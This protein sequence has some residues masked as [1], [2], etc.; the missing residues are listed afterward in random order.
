L[1]QPDE[2]GNMRPDIRGSDNP[3]GTQDKRSNKSIFSDATLSPHR[4]AKRSPEVSVRLTCKTDSWLF[5]LAGLTVGL[6]YATNLSF[7]QHSTLQFLDD[8][9]M[10]S[11]M[12]ANLL[13]ARSIRE[14]GWLNPV[15]YH[16]WANWMQAIAPYPQWVEW[17]GGEQ[18]FQQS[19]LYAY[20]L[21]L[22]VQKLVLMRVLQALISIGTCIFLG[23]FTA[24]ICGRLAGWLAFWLA[25]LYAPFYAY[26][27]PFLRDGIAWFI[28]AA[29]LWA[30]SEL[31]YS[32]WPSA[33][34]RQFGWLAG[35]LMGLGF[36]ARETYLLLIPVVLV[37]L[38]VFAWR[39]RQFGMVL[40]VAVAT[41]L[42]LSPLMIRNW[43][44]KAPLFSTSN[45]LAETMIHGN[46]GTAHPYTLMVPVETGRILHETGAR[47]LP[48]LLAAI[49]SH[50]DGVRGWMRLQLLK[51]L[52]LFD[53]YESPDNLSF[54]FIATV[55]PVV[56]L[57]LRY[58]MILPV[59]LA[60]LFLSIRSG[61]KAHFWIWTFLPVFVLSL[62]VGVP[63]SRYR[64]SLMVF[65]IPL[66]AYFIVFMRN[67]IG[68]REI[69][70]AAFYCAALLAGWA[71]I[72]GPLSRQPRVLYD[73][74]TEYLLSA[75]VFHEL[76]KEQK[77]QA[78]LDFVRRRFP[79]AVP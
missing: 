8:H 27:W 74:P 20:V 47:P 72:L 51:F 73:R 24:R 31:T 16:P 21:S 25:A 1:P 69:H 49:S 57:G 29:L 3:C 13:W 62:F 78:M 19:P 37:A 68:R 7:C 34:A 67:L 18:V 55:S 48:V 75:Q 63:L 50:P 2:F 39:R 58:W 43:S 17:W 15:P 61:D 35:M 26:S 46:A 36:L 66:A 5:A 40:P 65:F 32:E 12:H 59:A 44:V 4:I 70:T 11:D 6:L 41:V 42:A 71:L 23:L 14:Q 79:D 9:F 45:R 53:P 28:T 33:R 76:G 10:N 64:Q 77:A 52:S 22:F 54:Y 30:L 60:G 38:A 56:R